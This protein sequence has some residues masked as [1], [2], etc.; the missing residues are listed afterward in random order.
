MMPKIQPC[1]TMCRFVS[2]P[3]SDWGDY[4]SLLR[5]GLLALAK[6]TIKTLIPIPLPFGF[7]LFLLFLLF[8]L[9]L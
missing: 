8:R 9:D 2:C 6:E 7:A 4:C 5:F 1:R 3:H